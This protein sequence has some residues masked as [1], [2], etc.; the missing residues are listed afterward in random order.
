MYNYYN[1]H[2]TLFFF[3][4]CF[5]VLNIREVNVSERGI[6]CKINF[7]IVYL[8]KLLFLNNKKKFENYVSHT[9]KYSYFYLTRKK[10]N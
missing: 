3:F 7:N 9:E 8:F 1:F 10:R 6:F 5:K 4:F 2:L